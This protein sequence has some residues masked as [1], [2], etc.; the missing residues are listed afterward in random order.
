MSSYLDTVQHPWTLEDIHV[1]IFKNFTD[2]LESIEETAG[3]KLWKSPND[4]QDSLWIFQKSTIELLDEICVFGDRSRDNFFWHDNARAE[5]HSREVKRYVF[6]CTSS[7]MALVDHA[8]VFERKYP[9]IGYKEHLVKFFPEQGLHN[10]LQCFRNYNTH[11]RV[12]EANWL[13]KQNLQTRSREACFTIGKHELLVWNGWDQRAKRFIS[14]ANE[15]ID[16]YK[17]FS[18]YRGHVQKFYAWHKGAVLVQYAS[19]YKSYLEY[20][21]LYDG[22]QKKI[23]WNMILSKVPKT[24]NPYEY[25]GRYESPRFFRRR[26]NLSYAT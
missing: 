8:R 17:V 1:A 10:F 24:L 19:T 7:L 13:I 23:Y 3:G 21:R 5:A 25:F 12:A 2:A 9:V 4:L 11:W 14:E 15:Y 22:L 6:N 26:F 16:I 18:L 20:K